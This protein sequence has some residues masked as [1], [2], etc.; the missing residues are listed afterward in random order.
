MCEAREFTDNPFQQTGLKHVQHNLVNELSGGQ[1]RRVGL[2]EGI[3]FSP[4]LCVFD[5]PTSGL[6]SET[7]LDMLHV[8]ILIRTC[9]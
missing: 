7:A 2:A 3:S 1:R 8:S 6:D 5:E 4:L 9:K